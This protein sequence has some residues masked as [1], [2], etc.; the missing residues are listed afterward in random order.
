MSNT[1]VIKA[2][3]PQPFGQWLLNQAT[4]PGPI[5]ALAQCANRDP[6]FPRDGNPDAVSYR[7][8]FVGA[9]GEM[10]AALEDAELDWASY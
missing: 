6:A 9:G 2:V 7:L 1:D 4:R 8:N 3:V 10:H 5:G